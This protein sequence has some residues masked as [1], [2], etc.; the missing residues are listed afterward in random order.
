MGLTDGRR[1]RGKD[2]QKLCLEGCLGA[3]VVTCNTQCIIWGEFLREG[4]GIGQWPHQ[5]TLI[6]R[7][8]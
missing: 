2:T 4:S 6:K 3:S 5:I 7:W 8:F 1:R